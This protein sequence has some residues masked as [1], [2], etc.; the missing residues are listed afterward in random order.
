MVIFL[1][2]LL[3]IF[4]FIRVSPNLVWHFVWGEEKFWFKSKY[5]DQVLDDIAKKS[6]SF[7]VKQVKMGVR[8]S[9]RVAAVCKTVTK[10]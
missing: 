2:L 1:V 7:N 9:W 4:D 5:P 8:R 10:G 6:S 3:F